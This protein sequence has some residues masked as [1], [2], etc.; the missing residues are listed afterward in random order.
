[1][2]TNQG[3]PTLDMRHQGDP[4]L[5]AALG[6]ALALQSRAEDRVTHGFHTY[7]AGL[8]PDAAGRILDLIGGTSVFDPFVG[9]GTVLVEALLRGRTASGADVSPTALRVARARTMLSD[10]ALRTSMRAH[11]RRIAAVGRERKTAPPPW[12]L[13]EVGE[14]YAPWVLE[15]LAS[16]WAE[17]RHLEGPVRSLLEACFSSLLV[18]VSWRA[19]DTSQRRV[20]H[21]RP[22]GTTSVLFHKKARELGRRLEALR[23]QVP[24]GTPPVRLHAADAREPWPASDVDAVVTSPPYPGVYDYVPLQALRLAWFDERGLGHEMGSRRQFRHQGPERAGERWADEQRVWMEQAARVIRPGGH[25]VIVIGD[26]LVRDTVIDALEPVM[27]ST[28]D[29]LF[30][31]SAISSL[32]RPDHARGVIRWEH[33]I[34]A[35]R[36]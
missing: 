5:A 2:R 33:I 26:G 25:L 36:S 23:A 20:E 6:E 22:P 32:A 16:I 1:M 31:V 3:K 11:A 28:H 30:H 10:D 27:R 12:L 14:W 18:K 29:S 21:R 17:V 4:T 9:G 8:H 34:C 13:D 7:P 24:E 35:K 15:E 19:S